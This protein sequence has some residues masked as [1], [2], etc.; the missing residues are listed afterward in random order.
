ME[1]TAS[2]EAQDRQVLRAIQGMLCASP[3]LNTIYNSQLF[4]M[5]SVQTTFLLLPRFI[6]FDL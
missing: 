2:Q 3:P 4:S 6:D 1:D 5:L